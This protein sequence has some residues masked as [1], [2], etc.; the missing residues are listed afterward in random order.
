M[1]DIGTRARMLLGPEEVICRVSY[2]P[3]FSRLQQNRR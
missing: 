3:E 2:F 1:S